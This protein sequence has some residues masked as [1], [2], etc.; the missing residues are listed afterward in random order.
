MAQECDRCRELSQQVDKILEKLTQVTSSQLTEY[1]RQ[2]MS[3]FMAL[4]KELELIVGEK[5]R[6]IGELREHRREHGAADALAS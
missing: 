2:N 5:E 1:R 4:D 3:R 6:S